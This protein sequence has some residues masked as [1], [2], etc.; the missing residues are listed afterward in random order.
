[1]SSFFFIIVFLINFFSFSFFL[2]SFFLQFSSDS[3]SIFS[4]KVC[5]ANLFELTTLFINDVLFLLTED[6]DLGG[7]VVHGDVP[8][9]VVPKGRMWGLTSGGCVDVA[10]N[11]NVRGRG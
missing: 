9:P 2:A 8:E 11:W 7:D 10:T 1:M 5:T 6:D 3:N 4:I